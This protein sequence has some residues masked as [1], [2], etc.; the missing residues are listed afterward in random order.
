M[1]VLTTHVTVPLNALCW[2]NSLLPGGASPF[3]RRTTLTRVSST[4]SRLMSVGN[5]LSGMVTVVSSVP[6]SK[7]AL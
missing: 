3:T 5:E 2:L 6:K 7:S 1:A 4:R